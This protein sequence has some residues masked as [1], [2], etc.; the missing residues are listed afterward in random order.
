MK[1]LRPMGQ[2]IFRYME[3]KKNLIPRAA[4]SFGKCLVYIY[5]VIYDYGSFD[6]SPLILIIELTVFYYI[7]LYIYTICNLI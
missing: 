7:D 2:Y 4:L 6:D 5:E 1:H 3:E